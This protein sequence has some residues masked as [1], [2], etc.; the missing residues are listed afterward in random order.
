MKHSVDTF[1]EE[2]PQKLLM[3]MMTSKPNHLEDCSNEAKR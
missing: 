3:K 2:I 1:F